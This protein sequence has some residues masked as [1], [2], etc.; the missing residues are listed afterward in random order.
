MG[1]FS[2][3][4]EG[5]LLQMALD[6]RVYVACS[7]RNDNSLKFY[8]VDLGERKKT[9]I[10][11]LKYKREDRWANYIK[12]VIFSLLNMGHP[13][14][15]MDFTVMGD[16]PQGIGLG[17][18]AALCISA[19]MAIRELFSLDLTDFQILDTARQAELRFIGINSGLGQG[20]VSL[21]GEEGKILFTDLREL[22]NEAV[23][24]PREKVLFVL[25]NSMVPQNTFDSE[26][27]DY[28]EEITECVSFLSKRKAGTSLR[29]FT[30]E[31]MQELVGKISEEVRRRCI[32]LIEESRRALEVK[33]FLT[34]GQWESVG[35]MMNRSH[36]GLRDLWEASCPEIDWLVKRAWETPGVYGS[37]M[38]GEGY[39][40]CTVSLMEESALEDYLHHLEEYDRIFGFTPEY[41]ILEPAHGA[42]IEYTQ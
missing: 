8:S 22:E 7:P 30:E 3:P 24:Y 10:S 28:Q 16:I 39:G 23:T 2:S 11:S 13:L 1:E 27:L 9:S 25:T 21:K 41:T 5:L 14:R 29:D 18:S 19:A 4:G 37:K 40:G 26:G 38:T 35:K 32:H 42:K 36:E 31:D 33:N 20:M 15:G 17:S 6:K 34:K 12:G